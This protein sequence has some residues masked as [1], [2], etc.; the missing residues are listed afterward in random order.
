MQALRSCAGIAGNEAVSTGSLGGTRLAENSCVKKALVFLAAL[1]IAL[2]VA[3]TV[4]IVHL[5][6][7]GHRPP[8]GTGVVEGLDVDVISRLSARID[9]VLVWEGDTVTQGQLVAELDCTEQNAALEQARAQL[10]SASA[11]RAASDS[12]AAS[13]SH[14]A[15]AA[16]ANIHV[17]SAQLDVLVAQERLARIELDRTR[18]LVAQGAVSQA[19]LDSAVARDDALLAQIAG[20]H[21]SEGETRDQAVAASKTRS[22]TEARVVAAQGELD[23]ARDAVVRAEENVRECKLFAPRN[24]IVATRVHEPGEAVQ[25]GSVILTIT[26][27]SD[28]RTR[29]YIPNA[30]LGAAAPGG[31]VR[32]VAD[33]Y[34]NVA[35]DGTIYYVSPRAEFTPRNVET[36]EDRERLVYAVEV[37]I[38][39]PDMKLRAGMPVEVTIVP[40][41][42]PPS[43][44]VGLR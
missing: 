23:A 33:A 37:R 17:A 13:A 18:R 30:E 36:R 11:E 27:L 24:G 38:A 1:A 15:S 2:V 34:A 42:A 43:T 31:K 14:T 32:V 10:A 28:A 19:E 4:R 41:P 7:A 22:A 44:V 16:A 40:G 6:A 21:A 29:F 12:S 26:D 39:N 20:Q 3:L 35:F 5:R 25:P 8:G 9:K